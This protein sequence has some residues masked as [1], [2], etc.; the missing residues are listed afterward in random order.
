MRS[1]HQ[2]RYSLQHLARPVHWPEDTA[3]DG[4]CEYCGRAGLPVRVVDCAAICRPCAE[5]DALGEP[6]GE[7]PVLA[8]GEWEREEPRG[9]WLLAAVALIVVTLVVGGALALLA[10]VAR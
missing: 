10:L 3:E 1:P 8:I 9:P 6:T 7:Q 2:R 4:V 5:D